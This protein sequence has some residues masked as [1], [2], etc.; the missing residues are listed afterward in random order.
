MCKDCNGNEYV[1]FGWIRVTRIGE[2]FRIN[3]LSA[4][5]KVKQGPEILKEDV[6][7]MIQAFLDLK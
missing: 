7:K 3:A 1:E 5:G 2:R 6:G 4:N